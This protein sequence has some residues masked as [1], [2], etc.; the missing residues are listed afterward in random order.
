[1]IEILSG[2]IIGVLTSITAWYVLYHRIVPSL[3][4]FPEI[5]KSKTDENQSGYKYRVRFRNNGSREI[6]D[7]E[8]FAKLRIKG[9]SPSSPTTWRAIYIPIDDSRIPRLK[10]QKGT[11]KRIAVQLLISEIPSSAVGSLP[12]E[13]QKRMS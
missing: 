12:I 7:L 6:I 11:N 2:Y 3:E 5:Y 9:L 10:S 4:F 8:L 13:L 1:M